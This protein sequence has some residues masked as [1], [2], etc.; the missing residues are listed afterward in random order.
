MLEVGN[1]EFPLVMKKRLT[2]WTRDGGKPWMRS[3][4]LKAVWKAK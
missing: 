4:L 3:H 2:V 1:V